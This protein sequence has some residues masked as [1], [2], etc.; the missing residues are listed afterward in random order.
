[1]SAI[2]ALVYRA[3][4]KVK[5]SV[6]CSGGEVTL[7]IAFMYKQCQVGIISRRLQLQL[8]QPGSPRATRAAC[9]VSRCCPGPGGAAV[10]HAAANGGGGVGGLRY[11]VASGRRGRRGWRWRVAV[12]DE[13]ARE[14]GGGRG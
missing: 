10:A 13:R 5:V 8:R 2:A 4:G 7:L 11:Q 12:H 6:S 3:R 1:M 14:A 9:R